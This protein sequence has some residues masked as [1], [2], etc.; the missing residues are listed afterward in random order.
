MRKSA[1]YIY[2]D[3]SFKDMAWGK[4]RNHNCW[5]AEITF[6][7]KRYRKRSKSIEVC[8]RFIEEMKNKFGIK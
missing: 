3:K 2:F 6:N 8:E 4:A 5:C 7:K 1:G